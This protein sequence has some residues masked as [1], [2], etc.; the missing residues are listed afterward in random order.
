MGSH[1]FHFLQGNHMI[2]RYHDSRRL[3]TRYLHSISLS[4]SMSDYLHDAYIRFLCGKASRCPPS[5]SEAPFSTERRETFSLWSVPHAR[6]VSKTRD[7]FFLLVS[8]GRKWFITCN[9]RYQSPSIGIINFIDSI[10]I[11][12]INTIDVLQMD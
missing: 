10:R 7:P 2:H 5:T 9:F 4:Y 6:M 1:V 11:P 8:V 12:S 3:K